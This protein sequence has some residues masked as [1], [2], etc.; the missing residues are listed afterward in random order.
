MLRH[1]KPIAR[2]LGGIAEIVS[3]IAQ[4]GA[5]KT[6]M[7]EVETQANTDKRKKRLR[8]LTPPYILGFS[9]PPPVYEQSRSYLAFFRALPASTWGH[10]YVFCLAGRAKKPYQIRGNAF[11][12]IGPCLPSHYPPPA[13]PFKRPV[14]Q[15]NQ[16]L[17]G[18]KNG[19]AACICAKRARCCAFFGTLL[20][21]FCFFCVSVLAFVH[22]CMLL[23]FSAFFPA[24]VA[25]EKPENCA[26]LVQK[27]LFL[28]YPF[29]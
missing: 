16:A 7:E 12:P 22:F 17:C 5:T 28:Q 9:Y 25:V 21:F 24:K 1:Q 29:S 4:Y 2:R 6:A 27:G 19:G 10:Y 11:L 8:C 18:I 26:E 14:A 20:C 3:R 23:H 15:I 13:I